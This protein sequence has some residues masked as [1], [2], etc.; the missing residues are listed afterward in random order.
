MK[1]SV[2]MPVYN[3]ARTIRSIIDRVLAVDLEKEVIVVDDGSTDGTRGILGEIR[4]PRVKVHLQ[5]ANRGKGAALRAGFQ[6]ATTA[7]C[8]MALAGVAKPEAAV[9]AALARAV[10]NMLAVEPAARATGDVFYDTWAHVYRLE[11]F[12]VLGRDPRFGAR[13]DDLAAAAR[14]EIEIL[15]ARQGADGGF[16][17]YDFGYSRETP[18][19]F[20]ST[21]VSLS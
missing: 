16:G 13:R 6:Q 4:E 15:R 9:D 10:E 12:G 19:G 5:P 1:V 8:A 11:A 21:S 14:R 18:S 3:E 2:V 20:E 17:Y 7:L